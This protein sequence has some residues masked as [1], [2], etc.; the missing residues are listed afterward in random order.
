MHIKY[1]TVDHSRLGFEQH[2]EA[3]LAELTLAQNA[4]LTSSCERCR[5]PNRMVSTC[6]CDWRQGPEVSRLYSGTRTSAQWPM[7]SG[8]DGY[9]WSISTVVPPSQTACACKSQLL[10]SGGHRVHVHAVPV[11]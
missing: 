5:L 4:R 2:I 9:G 11:L 6:V 3:Q 7:L 8:N 1:A 10:M